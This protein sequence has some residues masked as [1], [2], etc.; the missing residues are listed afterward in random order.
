MGIIKVKYID[1]DIPKIQEFEKGDWYDL[2]CSRVV[3]M[4]TLMVA[5]W[6]VVEDRPMLVRQDARK[7][8]R[9]NKG[10]F[11]E[12]GQDKEVEYVR[13]YKGDALLVYLGV[14]MELPEGYEAYA[15]PRGSTFKTFG[16]IQTNS[17]GLIDSTYC[18]D[19]DE[20]FLP[21]R[22]MQDGFMMRGE[23]VCQFRVQRKME[24]LKLEE[25]DILGN[26]NRNSLGHSGTF[27]F[28]G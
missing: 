9:F 11:R 23:R 15:M 27:Q 10:I 7:E 12:G 6:E 26:P 25:V 17:L 4:T 19:D 1:K 8:L 5:D 13:Y 28:S 3:K 22:A 14:A 24:G 16:T 2:R 20:W 21:L 18:G